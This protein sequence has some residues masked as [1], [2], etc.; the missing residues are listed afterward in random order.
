MI[1]NAAAKD[2]SGFLSVGIG[3]SSSTWSVRMN[4][5]PLV[6]A[7]GRRCKVPKIKWSAFQSV[8]VPEDDSA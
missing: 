1:F 7:N 8:F 3:I 5:M 2:G 4:V 6:A